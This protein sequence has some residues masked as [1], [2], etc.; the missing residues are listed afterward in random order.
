VNRTRPA[1]KKPTITVVRK[2]PYRVEGVEDIKD[3]DGQLLPH[4]PITML[5]RCGASR[6]KPFCDG[7][8]SKIGFVGGRDPNRAQ[9][10]TREY[11]GNEITIVDDTNVCCRDRS[12]ITGLPQVFETCDP[13]AASPEDIMETIR[14]C[15]SGA[16]TY[17][18]GGTHC[19]DFGREPGIV[20]T[21]NGPLKV[22]GGISLK[23]ETGA[24]P[25]CE[26]HYTLCRCGGSKN[27]PFCDG[28]HEDID[29]RDDST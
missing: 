4:Q 12:C 19:H 24:R 11:A 28:T 27:K 6:R 8:H 22:V 17:K 2:G 20:V 26:E 16:L 23:D 25:A 9:G 29:F 21:K 13:D 3:S 18:M 15:P 7:T 1:K 10:E 5:C 14:K